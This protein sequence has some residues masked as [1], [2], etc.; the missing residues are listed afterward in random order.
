MGLN[1][2]AVKYPWP[3][4]CPSVAPNNHGWFRGGNRDAIKR[5]GRGSKIFMELGSWLGKSTLFT[6]RTFKNVNVIAIDTWNGS[7]EHQEK[8]RDI[9]PIL[10][11]TFLCNC[12]NY[13]NRLYPLRMDTM[14][15]MKEVCRFGIKPDCIFID[16]AHDYESIYNDICMANKLFP[17][18]RLCGDDY[19]A[20][21]GVKRAVNEFARKNKKKVVVV[22]PSWIL[23]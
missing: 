15:G 19:T 4:E 3:K 22:A 11:K 9:L 7:D 6:L 21:A 8:Y 14:S 12:W 23:R 10:Y 16:A 13:R 17:S 1:E 20:K 2:L 5:C 18:A